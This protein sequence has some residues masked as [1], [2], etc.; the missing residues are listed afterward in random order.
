MTRKAA[1]LGLSLVA[2]ALMTAPSFA[3]DDRLES[4]IRAAVD[5]G[6]L[7]GLHAVLV[8]VGEHTLA[9]LYFDGEDEAWG[10]PLG[11][12][13]HGPDTLHDLR[14]VSKSITSLLYGIALDEGLVPGL[15]ESLVAQFPEYPDLAEDPERRR[16]LV[17]HAL[18]MTMGTEWDET[19][20]YTDPRNSEIAMEKAAD[21]Y[22][23]LLDRPL[24][25]EPGARWVYNGGATA[26]IA[27]LIAKGVGEPIDAYAKRKL[28]DP[29][30]I[31]TYEWVR[32]ADG[33][34]AAASGL[35]LRLGDLAKIGRMIADGGRFGGRR[36]VSKEWLD[37]SFT[38]QT[39]AEDSL[40][41]GYF[42]WLA[43][44]RGDAE[45]RPVWGAGFGNGGQRLTIGFDAKVVVAVFA[46][47]YN[48]PDA[49]KVP[50]T[51]IVDHV[52]PAIE[53]HL[54]AQ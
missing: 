7:P 4:E 23:F 9:E 5:A 17:R 12:V 29:L 47:N 49:W 36:I 45:S 37:A 48:Q 41:Y 35:R 13:V 20:P 11:E 15:N 2:L 30:G 43:P 53:R 39:A 8:M 38:P 26:A 22:R 44:R 52:N 32:G 31:E 34:P 51:V 19:R 18:T 50:V 16:I 25:D 54:R 6:D 42:W 46:G 28:F 3:E 10:R 33:E 27:R 21:R 14:S 24:V 40:R 1:R